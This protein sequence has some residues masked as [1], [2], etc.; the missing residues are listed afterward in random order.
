MRT[1][2]FLILLLLTV[3][4]FSQQEF[5]PVGAEWYYSQVVS[6]HPPQANY[7]KHVSV[8]DS[9]INDKPVKVIQKTKFTREDTVD[10]GFEYLH[11]NGDTVFYWKNAEFRELYNFSL[12]K[13]DSMLVYSD[14]FNFC[15]D[16]PFG[17]IG[18]DST[19]TVSINPIALKA[20]YS[21]HKKGSFWGFDG[22]PIIERIGSTSYLLPKDVAC[23]A[24][25][26]GIGPLRCY[27]D[28]EI[29]THYFGTTT[30][31]TITTFPV[32]AGQLN[33]KRIFSFYPNPVTDYLT[34]D[35]SREGTFSIEI[36]NNTGEI[37]RK[38]EFSPGARI[39]LSD[40]PEGLYLVVTK[41]KNKEPYY[42][43]IIKI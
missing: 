43:K 6:Y 1:T 30:C 40:L 11:Q 28:P 13:G 14:Q 9:A 19:F 32:H 26:P 39:N 42:G 25:D 2:V 18:I 23:I 35:S 5:A 20:Y 36:Y 33:T 17:W 21:S 3:S 41:N 8:K 16:S 15:T 24:D 22:N 29:G 37:V 12:A 4:G 34:I 38:Q 10:L 27:S 31:D 7:V